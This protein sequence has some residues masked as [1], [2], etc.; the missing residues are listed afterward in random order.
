MTRDRT[1]L[2]TGGTEV[3]ATVRSPNKAIERLE[4]AAARGSETSNRAVAIAE[5][6]EPRATPRVT[7]YCR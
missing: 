4:S 5:E 1:V 6:L 3:K 7:Y 2:T